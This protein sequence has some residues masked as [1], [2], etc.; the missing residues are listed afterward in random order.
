MTTIRGFLRNTKKAITSLDSDVDKI[1]DILTEE[2]IDL[3]RKDQLF[4]RSINIHGKPIGTYAHTYEPDLFTDPAG[5]PKIEGKPYN[6]LNYGDFFR[7]FKVIKFE[8]GIKIE[9]TDPKLTDIYKNTGTDLLGLTIS[10]KELLNCELI[11]PKLRDFI[12]RHY[13]A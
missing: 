13:R 2:I 8:E 3:N 7:G 9:N 10:N 6:L 5:Y 11:L 12:K 1:I 4:E